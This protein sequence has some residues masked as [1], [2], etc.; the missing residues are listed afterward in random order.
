M[1]RSSVFHV[2]IVLMVII[3]PICVVFELFASQKSSQNLN[4]LELKQD[5]NSTQL[6]FVSQNSVQAQAISDA[7]QDAGRMFNKP[8]WFFAGCFFS[9]GGAFVAYTYYRP[10]PSVPLLGKSPEYVAYY[11]DTYR[12]EM[13][14]HRSSSAAQGCLLSTVTPILMYAMYLIN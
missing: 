12:N 10:V 4:R 7:E 13:R 1:R 2:L 14:K 6:V 9:V 3:L 8:I 11:S 5:Q